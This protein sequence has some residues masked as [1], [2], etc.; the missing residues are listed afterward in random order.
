[1]KISGYIL[2]LFIIGFIGG[3]AKIVPPVGGPKDVTPPKVVKS[4][5]A[6]NALNF[7]E[8]KVVITFDEFIKFKDKEKEFVTSPPFKKKPEVILKYK[9]V[10]VNFR[11]D[12]QPNTTYSLN[13]GNSIT[14]NNE[15]NPIRDY[16][17]VF[18]TGDYIDSLSFEGKVVSAFDLKPDKER[19]FVM[20]YDVF[21]DS[22]PMKILPAYTSKTNEKGFF[23]I[24]HIKA[25]TFMV[26][27][28]KDL[29]NNLLYDLNEDI[30]F[31]DSL[32]Y[33]NNS[34]YHAPDTAAARDT[35]RSDSAYYSRFKPQMVLHSFVNETKKQFLDKKERKLNNQMFFSFNAP[36]DTFQISI[37]DTTIK[38][39][40]FLKEENLTHDSITLWITDTT[41]IKRDTIKT[42]LIYLMP[43]SLNILRPKYDTLTMIYKAPK[44]QQQRRQKQKSE[45]IELVSLTTNA[46]DGFDLNKIIS[47]EA[48]V[49]LD[50]ID[51][52]KIQFTYTEDTVYKP[53]KFKLKRDSIH[54][55]KFYI[56]FV[57]IPAANYS[58]IF[59]SLAISSI[60]R[61]YNDSTGIKFKA[62]K[63]DYYG[64]IKA[65]MSNVHGDIILQ[66][67]D[68]KEVIV[69]MYT[70]RN[71]QLIKL[72][73]LAPGKYLL[74]VIYDSNKN[75]RWDP[76]DYLAKKQPEKVEYYKDTLLVRSNWD[77][78]VSWELGEN[79]GKNPVENFT[80]GK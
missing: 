55:R 51:L 43:D 69:K 13:F 1:M 4:K 37:I 19:L 3:C 17:F 5:P 33:L 10:V 30:A 21:G 9:D 68:E 12:L 7:N 64:A 36:L 71:D 23:R 25:D 46:K 53:V 60:Y 35:A 79:E 80:K 14:D 62:Q 18:S 6:E 54:F 47:V 22:V 8:K 49:P 40:W 78:E 72:D 44:E 41:L 32:L 70:I 75:G 56:D 66:V 26:V 52:S 74:K 28:I 73:Y 20:L 38:S 34:F 57:P 59:D 63:E 2:I 27:T 50:S 15:G 31:S 11:E 58:L 48:N 61:T 39:P 65:T 29:N 76:G 24:N 42:V 45:N 77:V 67:L 16:E